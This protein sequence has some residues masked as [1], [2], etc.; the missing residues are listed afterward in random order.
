MATKKSYEKLSK[1][2][3]N[4]IKE[5]L[6]KDNPSIH[7]EDYVI[8]SKALAEYAKKLKMESV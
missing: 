2:L 5:K 6:V 8:V 3:I 7:F 1:I 4:S